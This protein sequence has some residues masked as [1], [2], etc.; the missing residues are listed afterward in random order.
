VD[1]YN[2]DSL[3]ASNSL[4]VLHTFKDNVQLQALSG[5]MLVRGVSKSLAIR[6]CIQFDYEEINY[7]LLESKAGRSHVV[8][9]YGI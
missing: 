7:A 2:C 4:S 1:E 8:R 6:A 5:W 3:D 9:F